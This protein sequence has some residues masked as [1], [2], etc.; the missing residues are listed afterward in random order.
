MKLWSGVICNTM[1]YAATRIRF[2]GTW[3]SRS[4]R[5]FCIETFGHSISPQLLDFRTS[6]AG[7]SKARM[8]RSIL[9]AF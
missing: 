1:S 4:C 9:R 2:H 5:G 3:I 7:S 6:A 8:I